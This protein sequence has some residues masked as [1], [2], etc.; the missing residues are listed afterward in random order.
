M[1]A[2]ASDE[3]SNEHGVVVFLRLSYLLYDEAA[4]KAALHAEGAA[5]MRPCL[6]CKSAV[7]RQHRSMATATVDRVVVDIAYNDTSRLP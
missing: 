1:P 5:G 6:C 3:A 7:G 2:L 4:T